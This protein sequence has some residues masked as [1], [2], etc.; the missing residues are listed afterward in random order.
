MRPRLLSVFQPKPIQVP[1]SSL[2]LRFPGNGDFL[3]WCQLREESSS[4]L[5]C[6]EPKWPADDLTKIGYRRRL[7]S[8]AQQRQSGWGQTFFLFDGASDELL[9]GIGL[10]R[11]THGGLRT[12]TLGYWMGSKHA[13]KGY[14][15][16][17]VPAMLN[18][19]FGEL[20]LNRVEAACVPRN[21]RSIHLLKKCGFREEGYA[22]EYLEIN[23]TREDHILFA[24]LGSEHV[25]QTVQAS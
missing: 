22:R 12:G 21:E 19:A 23:G 18:F 6:W 11:I 5:R 8:Y 14:M 13:G 15:R 10:T 2:V 20:M 1:E 25:Q 17:A 4:F 24:I 3:Q 16:K 9:G 7:K